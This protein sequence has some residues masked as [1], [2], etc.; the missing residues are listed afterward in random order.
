MLFRSFYF[1][2][3]TFLFPLLAMLVLCVLLCV[4]VFQILNKGE[5]GS[6]GYDIMKQEAEENTRWN[7]SNHLRHFYSMNV[8]VMPCL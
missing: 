2:S 8:I 4:F 5:W 6:L 1:M 7:Y 3:F